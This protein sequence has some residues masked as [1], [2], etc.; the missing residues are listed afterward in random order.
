[1]IMTSCELIDTI[2]YISSI[3]FQALINNIL[4]KVR[5]THNFVSKLQYSYIR[6][7]HNIALIVTS[8]T[9]YQLGYGYFMHPNKVYYHYP[10]IQ[11]IVQHSSMYTLTKN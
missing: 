6:I 7:S 11:A 5:K 3:S 1:M 4:I 8:Y 2:K 9:I 10:Q